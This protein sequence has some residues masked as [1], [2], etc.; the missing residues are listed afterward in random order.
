[1]SAKVLI[2]DDSALARRN[3]RRILENAGY[4]IIEADD[5]LRALEQ[6]YVHRPSVVILDLVMP[7]HASAGRFLARMDRGRFA[8]PIAQW[9]ALFNEHLREERFEPYAFGLPMVPLWQ[10]VY[11]VGVAR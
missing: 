8:R 10:M 11:F 4:D 9:R 5:G 6:Y 3:A 1:M 7:A 2:V